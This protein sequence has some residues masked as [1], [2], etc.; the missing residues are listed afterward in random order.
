MTSVE[1][2]TSA[3]ALSDGELVEALR[4]R[5]EAAFMALVDRYHQSLVRL[6]MSFVSTRAAAE[7]V[8]Q[9]TWLGVLNGIDR[10]EARS[11]LKTWLFRILVNRA[12]TRGV[13]DSRCVPFS[14]LASAAE[15]DE[16]PSVEPERFQGDEHRWAGHWSAPPQAWSGEERALARETREVIR[17]AID[18]LPPAQRAVISLRDVEGLDSEEV[19]AL[20]GLSDGNQRV[21]LHRARTKVRRALEDYL[22]PTAVTA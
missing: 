5:D 13:R 2:T 22:A 8:A 3:A 11:S 9:E 16:S 7:D 15:E 10:F 12:K 19:C 18:R 17:Q 6:A 14:S 20:L 21:L 1:Q 4:N